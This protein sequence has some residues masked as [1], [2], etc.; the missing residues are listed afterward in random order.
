[1]PRTCTA[2]LNRKRDSG[3]RFEHF[4]APPA[5]RFL[6]DSRLPV[7]AASLNGGWVRDSTKGKERNMKTTI[8]TVLCIAWDTLLILSACAVAKGPR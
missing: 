1:M 4:P 7:C 3:F 6:G 5:E 2:S 8:P